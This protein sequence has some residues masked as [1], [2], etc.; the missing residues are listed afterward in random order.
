MDNQAQEVMDLYQSDLEIPNSEQFETGALTASAL[1]NSDALVNALNKFISSHYQR[2]FEQYA[3]NVKPIN[4]QPGLSE[5]ANNLATAIYH[6]QHDYATKLDLIQTAIHHPIFKPS[7]TI[8]RRLYALFMYLQ[9]LVHDI[10]NLAEY[11]KEALVTEAQKILDNT[12]KKLM[13]SRD[14]IILG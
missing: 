7:K 8:R 10:F 4:E 11:P 9:Y 2:N 5:L 6:A 12:R 13:K 3:D 14:K 1:K